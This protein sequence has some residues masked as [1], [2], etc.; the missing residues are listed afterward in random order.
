MSSSSSS[1]TNA[2]VVRWLGR[3]SWLGARLYTPS[4][5]EQADARL[6]ELETDRLRIELEQQ[7]LAARI[8]GF[9]RTIPALHARGCDEQAAQQARDLTQA[10]LEY[11]RLGRAKRNT[12]A[13]RS[14]IAEMRAGSAVRDGLRFYAVTMTGRRATESPVR[15]ARLLA[16]GERVHD[17]ATMTAEMLDEHLVDDGAADTERATVDRERPLEDP[18]VAAV[19]TELGLVQ[20]IDDAAVLVP[21]AASG[22]SSSSSNTRR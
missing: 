5:Q 3:E 11:E 6:H 18:V 12:A 21:A 4:L 13:V 8:K 1:W 15:F 16:R 7:T 20:G 2:L 10:R 17:M 9:K 22:S 19:F 14:K